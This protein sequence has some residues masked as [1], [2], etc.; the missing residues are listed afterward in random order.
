MSAGD[1]EGVVHHQNLT[2]GDVA[3]TNTNHRNGQRVGDAFRQLNRH[4]LQHQQLGT[5]GFQRQGIIQQRLGGIATALHLIAAKDIDGLRR[6][7]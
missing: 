3:C 5:C 7:A 4:A 2:V 1:T 6:Q